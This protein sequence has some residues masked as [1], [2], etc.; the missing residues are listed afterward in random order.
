MDNIECGYCGKSLEGMASLNRRMYCSQ[1]CGAKARNQKGLVNRP[2][3]LWQHEPS[4]FKKAMEMY[5]SG[6]SSAVIARELDIP[7]G[8]MYSWVHDFGWQ[9]ERAKPVMQFE[10]KQIHNWSLKEYFRLADSAGEW[11]EILRDNAFQGEDTYEN[12]SVIL[13]CGTLH[14]QSAGKLAGIIYEK[15]KDD[16]LNGKTYAFCNKCRNAITT[17]AWNEPVYHISRYIKAYGTFI[18]PD[19]KLGS[20]IEIKR[21][22]FE[23]LIFLKKTR[24]SAEKACVNAG[25]MIQS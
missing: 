17:I 8:T 10:E 19:E 18:W 4:I 3:K 20:V 11:L 24:K 25:I 23:H 2:H 14:G 15:L 1:S 5:W 7:V 12:A 13:V 6:I 16:P 21:V 22:E 9:R